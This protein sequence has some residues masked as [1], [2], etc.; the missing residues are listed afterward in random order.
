MKKVSYDRGRMID[1]SPEIVACLWSNWEIYDA[2]LENKFK[3]TRV[4]DNSW[5]SNYLFQ[6]TL[7]LETREANIDTGRFVFTLRASILGIPSATVVTLR[8]VA[9]KSGETSVHGEFRSELLG[10]SQLLE[11]LVRGKITK[12][13]DEVIQGGTD[14][15]ILVSKNYEVVKSKL[16]E[17]FTQEIDAYLEDGKNL[18]QGK[19]INLRRLNEKPSPQNKKAR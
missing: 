1:T 3:I 6:S 17:K 5:I 19:L 8:Y 15:C 4:N 10:I 16:S 9:S 13:V 7:T 12:T 11:P 18:R 2:L 14:S